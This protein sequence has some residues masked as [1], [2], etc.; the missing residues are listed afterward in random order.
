MQ[1]IRFL[2]HC[3]TKRK[4]TDPAIH[5]Y[6]L[7]LYAK[8]PGHLGERA[9][10][11]FIESQGEHPAFDLKYA[12]RL[13]HQE[14]KTRACVSI[15]TIMGLFEEAVKLAL[16]PECND[17]ELAKR[18]A[19][20]PTAD[21][22]FPAADKKKIWLLIARHIIEQQQD[23]SKAIAVLKEFQQ[24]RTSDDDTDGSDQLKIEDILPF[25]PDFVK[26]A[27][28]KD[29][30]CESLDQY[31]ERIQKL[32]EEMEEHTKNADMIRKDITQLRNRYGYVGAGQKCDL[33]MQPVLTRSFLVFPCSH[34][35]H[36]DCMTAE[37]DRHLHSAGRSASSS[38]SLSSSSSSSSSVATRS[39]ALPD[40]TSSLNDS[41]SVASAAAASSF[42]GFFGDSRVR[43]DASAAAA[44]VEESQR[45]A[46]A[47]AVVAEKERRQRLEETAAAECLF[48]GDF[49]IDS[50]TEPFVSP[51]EAAESASWAL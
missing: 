41:A 7:A 16:S 1:A 24:L 21:D 29:E 33:C 51:D 19:E 4:N 47:A 22:D 23:I 13:C 50:V 44:A 36:M 40:A 26:I 37:L 31:N 3:V 14:R 6:L 49:M 27:D 30:I 32:K 12:L 17:L 10:L 20:T 2:D 38:S 8:I 25:F 43:G 28:F 34:V 45:T 11:R 5:N 15:Y 35:F 9:L 46:A 48:C 42:G 18:V 39:R